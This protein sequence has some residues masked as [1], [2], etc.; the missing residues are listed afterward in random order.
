LQSE[1][2]MPAARVKREKKKLNLL[3]KRPSRSREK[4][5]MGVSGLGHFFS[6]F[7]PLVKRVERGKGLSSLR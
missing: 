3:L 2:G 6:T 1:R 5:I 4:A 7:P